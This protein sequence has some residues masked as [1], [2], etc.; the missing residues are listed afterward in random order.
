[1]GREAQ[2][3]PT[4]DAVKGGRAG[5]THWS[6]PR[7]LWSPPTFSDQ[8]KQDVPS[9]PGPHGGRFPKGKVAL[10]GCSASTP[11]SPTAKACLAFPGHKLKMS[12]EIQTHKYQQ[13]QH[14]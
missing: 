13:N 1:M 10:R 6:G 9:G 11:D 14:P 5:V 7:P 8:G 2:D 3:I 4:G 12:W